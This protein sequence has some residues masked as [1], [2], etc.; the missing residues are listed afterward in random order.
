MQRI[1]LDTVDLQALKLL[2]VL[3]SIQPSGQRQAEA[4]ALLKAWDGRM[5]R[6]SAAATIFQSWTRH[7]KLD[8]IASGLR[9]DWRDSAQSGYINGLVD[10]VDPA[11]LARMLSGQGHAWCETGVRAEGPCRQAVSASLDKAMHELK[12][13]TGSSDMGDWRWGDVHQSAYDHTPFGHFRVLEK[14]FNRRVSAEGSQNAIDVSAS[15]FEEN[16]GYLQYFGPNMR[17]IMEP[18]STGA[19]HVYMNS[20][21]QSGNIMDKHYDDMVEPFATGAFWSIEPAGAKPAAKLL[22]EPKTP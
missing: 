20:T 1:Q 4:I 10:S 17:Q 13:L 21:G 11:Q 3:T 6:D 15:T 18:G 2:P 19:V 22:L 7:L 8:L 14:I 12:K 5:S 16:K 9:L